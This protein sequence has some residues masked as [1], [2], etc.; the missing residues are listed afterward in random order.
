MFMIQWTLPN[1]GY[2]DSLSHIHTKDVHSA[3]RMKNQFYDLYF[4]SYGQLYLQFIGD[5]PGLSSAS[6][7]KK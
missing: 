1:K 4:L 6:P 5:T 3:E 7:T 2:A